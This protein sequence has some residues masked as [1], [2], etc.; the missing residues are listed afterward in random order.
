M[1]RFD[2]QHYIPLGLDGTGQCKCI[3]GGLAGAALFSL[4]TWIRYG[5]AYHSLFHYDRLHQTKILISGA[6]MPDFVDILGSGLLGFPVILVCMIALL[7]WNYG[8]HFRDSKS[9]Y[10][11]RRLPQRWELLR[12]CATLPLAGGIASLC[13]AAL[14]FLLYFAVYLLL[15]PDPCLTGGQWHK[16]WAA[17]MGVAP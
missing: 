12:R 11:M 5:S 2:L 3:L 4:G 13:A 6:I 7:A 17:W 15:T 9:I 14:L 16:L 1:K 10:L 8:Y